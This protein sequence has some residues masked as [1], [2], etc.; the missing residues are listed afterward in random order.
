M[1][2]FILTIGILCSLISIICTY[3]I[4][5]R[6]YEKENPKHIPRSPCYDSY[7]NQYSSL[8]TKD[9]S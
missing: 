4:L 7:P 1:C 3:K 6:R 5:Q 8:P 9:V 2:G